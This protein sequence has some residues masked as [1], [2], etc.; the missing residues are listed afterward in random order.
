MSNN[1]PLFYLSI[2]FADFTNRKSTQKVPPIIFESEIAFFGYGTD[3][4]SDFYL[5][6][7]AQ[8]NESS[9]HASRVIGSRVSNALYQNHD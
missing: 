7:T 1:I 6:N 4:N 3:S 8:P 9:D 2:D 5:V